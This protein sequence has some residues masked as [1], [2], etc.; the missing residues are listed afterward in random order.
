MRRHITWLS[1]F[2][3]L[4]PTWVWANA[5]SYLLDDTAS[6]HN[7]GFNLAYLPEQPEASFEEIA[8]LPPEAWQLNSRR[9]LSLPPSPEGVWGRMELIKHSN[10]QSQ[11]LLVMKWPIIDRMQVRLYYPLRGAWGPVMQDGDRI[12]VHEHTLDHRFLLYPLDLPSNEPVV[13]YFHAQAHEALALPMQLVTHAELVKQESLHLAVIYLFFGGMLVIMLYNGCLYIFTRDRCYI[14]YLLYLCS[15]V[16]YEL[17]LTGL[18]QQYLWGEAPRFSVKA[19]GLFASLTFFSSLIF[20]RYFLQLKNYGGWLYHTNSVLIGYWALM[21]ALVLFYPP[22]LK[23]LLPTITPLIT[24]FFAVFVT[25]FLW[26]RGNVSAKH[27]TIAWAFLLVFTMIHLLAIA[28]RLPLTTFTLGSQMLGVYIEFILLSIALA[29][30]INRER[31]QRVEA[32]HAALRAS[33]HLAQAR[34]EKLLAQQKTLAAQREAKEQLEARVA[35]RTRDLEQTQARLEQ[36]IH[37]LAELS[38]KDSLTQL[39]NRRH[40]ESIAPSEVARAKRTQV[41]LSIL[42]IDIDHFKH[43]NDHY[44]HLFGDECLRQVAKVIQLNTQRAGDLAARYGGEEFIVLLPATS[45]ERAEQ[46]AEKIRSQV[47]NM[48]LEHPKGPLRPTLSIGITSLAQNSSDDIEHLI[49]QADLAL[50]EAKKS[51]RNQV[52]VHLEGVHS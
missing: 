13:L 23:Y 40:F 20:A 31:E 43:V 33:Q 17:T 16:G 27:F 7:I 21:S 52:C 48:T 14:A 29:E 47:E 39:Y 4:F 18:G 49:H 46:V 2:L 11:W 6:V 28:G 44:G 22:L 3:A 15:V 12:P 42:M 24:T 36:A 10:P 9:S 8:L 45:L 37:E 51:G 5:A 19:Y 30:R 41:A 35:E 50:Y 34:E 32:Q 26:A 38:I 1:L 25:A